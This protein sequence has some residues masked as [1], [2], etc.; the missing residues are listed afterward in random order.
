MPL[1]NL[2]CIISGYLSLYHHC[3]SNP[4]IYPSVT[5]RRQRGGGRTP[6]VLLVDIHRLNSNGNTLTSCHFIV[7]VILCCKPYGV[8]AS[9]LHMI[10]LVSELIRELSISGPLKSQVGVACGQPLVADLHMS[11]SC[12]LLFSG[13]PLIGTIAEGPTRKA[14]EIFFLVR[15]SFG[16]FFLPS[17]L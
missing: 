2:P 11:P 4:V 5:I 14:S 8:S 16:L 9:L 13:V 15:V 12:P 6:E 17:R 7:P 3:S 10:L 1:E